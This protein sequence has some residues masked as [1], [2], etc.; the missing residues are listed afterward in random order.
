MWS[1]SMKMKAII[2]QNA[3]TSTILQQYESSPLQKRKI[4]YYKIFLI[5]TVL[6]CNQQIIRLVMEQDVY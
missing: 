5:K 2:I 4:L 6:L 1:S 3:G